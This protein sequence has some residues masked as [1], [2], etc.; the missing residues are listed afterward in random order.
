MS[1]LCLTNENKV[2]KVKE[3]SVSLLS[4]SKKNMLIAENH[5]D[6]EAPGDKDMVLIFLIVRVRTGVIRDSF[7]TKQTKNPKMQKLVQI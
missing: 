2:N 5:V 7:Y 1:F 4:A 3:N 6:F